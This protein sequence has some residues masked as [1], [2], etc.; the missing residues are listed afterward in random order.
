ME[1]IILLLLL[2]ILSIGLIYFSK[3]FEQ[4]KWFTRIDRIIGIPVILILVGWG[5]FEIVSGQASFFVINLK[6]LYNTTMDD[7][8]FMFWF[9]VFAK[10]YFAFLFIIR[11]RQ[12]YGKKN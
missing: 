3:R 4:Q 9:Y 7:N 6:P 11:V 1:K 12:L 5:V 10:F 2:V 8:P